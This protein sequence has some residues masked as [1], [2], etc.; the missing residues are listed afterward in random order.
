[1]NEDD[2]RVSSRRKTLDE[3]REE[4]RAERIEA[5]K[6][7][8]L[9]RELNDMV[10]EREAAFSNLKKTQMEARALHEQQIREQRRGSRLASPRTAP[11]EVT[12]QFAGWLKGE[13]SRHNKAI[14]QKLDEHEE[15]RGK[16]FDRERFAKD[17][18]Y[19]RVIEEEFGRGCTLQQ[20]VETRGLTSSPE[21]PHR[22]RSQNQPDLTNPAGIV[23]LQDAAKESEK[24]RIEFRRAAEAGT[25]R[26]A[27]DEFGSIAADINAARRASGDAEV[28]AATLDERGMHLARV[29]SDEARASAAHEVCASRE[30]RYAP[31]LREGEYV[32][33][34]EQGQVYRLTPRTTGENSRDTQKFMA[35]LDSR[36]VS[37]IEATKEPI[38]GRP[39]QQPR[40]DLTPRAQATELKA[41]R[42]IKDLN[43]DLGTVDSIRLRSDPDYR[44]QILASQTQESQKDRQGLPGHQ[45]GRDVSR[46]R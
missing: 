7:P 14:D 19:R 10:Q 2:L 17:E 16:E 23:A 31:A 5:I 32:V 11:A 13:A 3:V 44:R 34:T 35:A 22:D 21:G 18:L 26:S 46:Q 9:A 24:Q 15:I 37:G 28:F 4:R 20:P 27:A 29:T 45:R 12:I 25:G 33:V 1:M 42:D 30:G 40:A 6:D 43:E 36:S 41:D 39:E 8:K 38:A